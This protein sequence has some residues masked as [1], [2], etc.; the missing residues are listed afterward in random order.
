MATTVAKARSDITME[1]SRPP[2]DNSNDSTPKID[3][4]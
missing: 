1:G 3:I 2:S 4:E